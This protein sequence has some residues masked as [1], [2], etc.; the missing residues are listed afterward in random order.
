[1]NGERLAELPADGSLTFERDW[2]SGDAVT[3][4]F[5]M[6]VRRVVA[7]ERAESDH[8]SVALQRGPLVYCLEWPDQ[9]GETALHFLLED[10]V[11]L[12][13]EDRPGLLGGVKVITAPARILKRTDAGGT[14]VLEAQLTAIPDYAGA[15]RG[16]GE[17][18]VWIAR[19]A[20]F[21]RPQ[22]LPT[23]ASTS[24]IEISR[25]VRGTVGLVDQLDPANSNDHSMPYVHWWP[26]F[27]TREWVEYHFKRPARVSGTRVYWFDDE[28]WGGCRI[29]A[30]WALFYRD[31]AGQWRPVENTSPF[32]CARNCYNETRFTPV[33]TDALRMEIQMQ[34]GVSGGIL[35]WAVV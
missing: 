22:P 6:P 17:M 9:P 33:E 34:P 10:H 7:D 31:A 2:K 15:H 5:P 18:S 3:I 27:G 32:G 30:S 25:N 8:G 21:A 20:G 29:P 13:V 23:I 4:E 35:E 12:R 26:N 19:D 28:P 14:D 1:M 24:R 16:A 11:P